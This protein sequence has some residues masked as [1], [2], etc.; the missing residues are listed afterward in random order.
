MIKPTMSHVL[1]KEQLNELLVEY[2][3]KLEVELEGRVNELELALTELIDVASECDSWESFP[4]HELYLAGR[5][6]NNETT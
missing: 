5:V 3:E 2:Y 6:L 1:K 4:V